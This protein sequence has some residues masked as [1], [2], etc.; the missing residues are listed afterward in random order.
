MF[1]N[2]KTAAI[3]FSIDGQVF[4]V[5]NPGL[6]GFWDLGGFREHKNPWKKGNRMAPFD[7]E[8]TYSNIKKTPQ[9][10]KII[11]SISINSFIST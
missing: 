4:G 5:I 6:G 1:N 10:V 2:F 7:K 8:V 9:N 11:T 3:T